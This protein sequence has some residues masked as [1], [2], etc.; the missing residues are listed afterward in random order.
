MSVRWA[1]DTG[2]WGALD[3]LRMTPVMQR[4]LTRTSGSA[5]QISVCE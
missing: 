1:E 4:L 2:E 5:T 3:P